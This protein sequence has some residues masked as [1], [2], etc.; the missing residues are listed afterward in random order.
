MKVVILQLNTK[1]VYQVF[2]VDSRYSWRDEY[3]LF[4][5]IADC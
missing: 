1:M 2:V 5:S 4:Y 3:D